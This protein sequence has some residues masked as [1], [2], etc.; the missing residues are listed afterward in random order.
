M[1]VLRDGS[2]WLSCLLVN[3]SQEESFPFEKKK[4]A[5]D[6]GIPN[7]KQT[8]LLTIWE[9]N[10]AM[11]QYVYIYIYMSYDC[12]CTC[13]I[14]G[15]WWSKYYVWAFLL[16]LETTFWEN[17]L[18]AVRGTTSQA[19]TWRLSGA[20]FTG[21]GVGLVLHDRLFRRRPRCKWL[22]LVHHEVDSLQKRWDF[23]SSNKQKLPTI[24]GAISKV[25]INTRLFQ[26][27]NADS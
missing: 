21:Q 10:M 23:P 5:G 7:K 20:T 16:V 11:T 18:M 24:N 4:H 22:T 3:R 17:F 14:S 12:I 27:R 8:K 15:K 13:C 2:W 1:L 9:A 25:V 19:K 6:H 26:D